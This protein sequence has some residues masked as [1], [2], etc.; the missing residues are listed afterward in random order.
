M[1]VTTS[2]SEVQGYNVNVK[3]AVRQ[4]YVVDAML[5]T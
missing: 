1:Q 5:C 4:A 3:I 2:M